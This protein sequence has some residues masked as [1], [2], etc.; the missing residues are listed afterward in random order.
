MTF[1]CRVSPARSHPTALLVHGDDAFARRGGAN[2]SNRGI[3]YSSFRSR[4]H[5]YRKWNPFS[6]VLLLE[7]FSMALPPCPLLLPEQRQLLGQPFRICLNFSKWWWRSLISSPPELK[8]RPDELARRRLRSR[9]GSSN[10]LVQ[11][12]KSGIMT[13]PSPLSEGMTILVDPPR[14]RTVLSKLLSLSLCPSISL[15]RRKLMIVLD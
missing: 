1:P 11:V 9:P 7:V 3:N 10:N 6:T 8:G 5:V 12:S 13:L 4:V 2:R 15:S 14:F